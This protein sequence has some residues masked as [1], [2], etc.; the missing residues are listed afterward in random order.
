MAPISNTGKSKAYNSDAPPAFIKVFLDS[1]DAVIV[2]NSIWDIVFVNQ[3]ACSLSGYTKEELL[4]KKITDYVDREQGQPAVTAFGQL[5]AAGSV[6]LPLSVKRINGVRINANVNACALNADYFLF[7]VKDLRADQLSRT[8]NSTRDSIL[9]AAFDHS[10]FGMALLSPEG[11]WLQV[12]QSFCTITGYSEEELLQMRLSDIASPHDFT[13]NESMLEEL[14]DGQRDYT[15]RE[16][17]YL[18]KNGSVVWV[19]VYMSILRDAHQRPLLFVL[20]GEDITEKKQVEQ[21]LME[22]N[23]LL[24]FFVQHSPAA[25]AMFDTD[26]RYIMVSRQYIADYQLGEIELTGKSHYDIFPNIPERWKEVHRQC[27]EGVEAKKEGDRFLLENGNVDWLNWEMLPWYNAEG[28]IGG[29]ILYTQMITEQKEAELKFR[30]LVEKS[31]VG[32][33]I[34]QDDRFVYVNPRFAEIFGYTQ[35]EMEGMATARIVDMSEREKVDRNI[36]A[37]IEGEVDYVHYETIG[38]KKDGSRVYT[39]AYGSHTVYKGSSAIIGSLLDITERKNAELQSRQKTEQLTAI[40]NNLPDAVIYQVVRDADGIMH[41]TYLSEGVRRLTGISPEETMANPEILYHIVHEDDI[42]KLKAAEKKSF[43]DLTLFNIDVRMNFYYGEERLMNLRSTPQRQ[44]DGSVVWNGLVTDITDRKKAQEDILALSRLYL[45]KSKVNELLLTTADKESILSSLCEI[46]VTYGNFRMAWVGY[47]NAEERKI[48][49]YNAAGFDNGYLDKVRANPLKHSVDGNTP[50][51]RALR[52]GMA[53]CSND[54]AND[55]DLFFW[56]EEA[57]QRNFLSSAAIPV[58]VNNETVAVLALYMPQTFFFTEAEMEVLQNI[59]QSIAFGLDKIRL[60]EERRKAETGLI[61][62]IQVNRAMIAAFPDKVSRIRR[63]GTIVYIHSG[64]E[65]ALYLPAEQMISRKV[66]HIAPDEVAVQIM[67]AIEKSLQEKAV[68]QLEYTLFQNGRIHYYEGRVAPIEIP[69]DEQVLFIARDITEEKNAEAA[70]KASEEKFRTLI[71]KTQ[72]G[73][74]ILQDG[75]IQFANP[76][77]EK[78]VGYSIE[79]MVGSMTIKDIVHPDDWERVEENVRIR[80]SGEIPKEVRPIHVVR[81]DGTTILLDTIASLINYEG[82]PAVIV[83]A[84]DITEKVAEEERVAKAVT[85]AQEKERQQIGMELHDNVNQ[86]LV[87]GDM[88]LAFIQKKLDERPKVEEHLQVARD[89]IAKAIHDLRDISHQ[90]TPI[91][92][93]GLPLDQSIALLV[94]RMDLLSLM[95]VK[96]HCDE[97]VRLLSKE[98]HLALYRILQEQINN[99]IKYARAKLLSISVEDKGKQICMSVVDD[100]TG[101]DLSQKVEGIGFENM[102]RRIKLLH[103][104]LTVVSA[105]GK[106]CALDIR[107]P[108]Q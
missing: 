56:K 10:P 46:A 63:D 93:G 20:Q 38:I 65:T 98:V 34:I 95:E 57:L 60:D 2:T 97:S 62:N 99:I 88:R 53:Q 49:P 81:K 1:S 8:N 105:P 69:G 75:K 35:N 68:K 78:I 18:H 14:A 76:V 85:D 94:K 59:T 33:Y 47:Y 101:F 71:E 21:I 102:R 6:N 91:I 36:K 48:V 107:I 4:N 30:N 15:F 41:F 80:I 77:L 82:K 100:G 13:S 58:K 11:K 51:G 96:T 45:L 103:G 39:E 89:I 87:A 28:K 52:T 19:N 73:V 5:E 90:L 40:S 32:V 108:K 67:Q 64:N 61:E 17:R 79:E 27:M 29:A 70:L 16:N 86:L 54:I 66:E 72:L 12:N 50:I 84:I 22:K 106:G 104:Q 3:C 26:M 44:A 25:L 55:P 74:Y 31:Q 43:L 42:E 7:I 83:T 37:R 9:S 24:Q 92:E 23:R